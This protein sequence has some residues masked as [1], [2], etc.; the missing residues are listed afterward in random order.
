MTLVIT[1]LW[2]DAQHN[3]KTQYNDTHHFRTK[4]KNALRSDT[5]RNDS[6]HNNTQDGILHC[7]MQQNIIALLSVIYSV[8]IEYIVAT[9]VPTWVHLCNTHELTEKHCRC[10]SHFKIS[11]NW[12]DWSE[13]GGLCLQYWLFWGPLSKPHLSI[14]FLR[15][16]FYLVSIVGSEDFC[17]NSLKFCNLLC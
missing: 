2:I 17:Q 1:T 13:R 6:H 5:Q 16:H 8:T 11:S 9:N 12:A 15:E 10:I 7:S 4:N 3:K 14:G